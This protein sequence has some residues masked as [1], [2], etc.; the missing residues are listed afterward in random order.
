VEQFALN[1]H[2]HVEVTGYSLG[3]SRVK[4]IFF[5]LAFLSPKQ[6]STEG[7]RDFLPGRICEALP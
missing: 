1:H 6:K 2:V 5:R 3:L 4:K 7:E